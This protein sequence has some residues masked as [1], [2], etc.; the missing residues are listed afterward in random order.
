M[1]DK[2]RSQTIINSLLADKVSRKFPVA[3]CLK[4]IA[5]KGLSW[6]KYMSTHNQNFLY[7]YHNG[8]I[9]PYV[10]GFWVIALAKAGKKELS[11]QELE[12]LAKANQAN[13]WQFNEWFH[14]RTGKPMGMPKQSW[15]AGTFLLAYH[16]LK[17]DFK[18]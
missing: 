4:P 3:V 11:W 18:F 16:F 12:K 7:Q 13:N 2:K 1:A 6:R 8:G 15:N 9:W 17:G 5:G 14:G 10:G